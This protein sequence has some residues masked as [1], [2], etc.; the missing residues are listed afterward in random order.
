[1]FRD[2]ILAEGA[3]GMA[4]LVTRMESIARISP[5]APDL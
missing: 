5:N 4:R 1:M 2:F 3:A